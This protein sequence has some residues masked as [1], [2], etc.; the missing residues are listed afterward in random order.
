MEGNLEESRPSKREREREKTE[1]EKGKQRKRNRKTDMND[2]E[3]G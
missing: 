1:K 3:R 2:L